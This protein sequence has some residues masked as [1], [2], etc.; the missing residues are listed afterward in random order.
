MHEWIHSTT[1]ALGY[2]GIELLMF[3]ENVFPPL[4]SELIMPLAGFA[5]AEGDLS[6]VGV[7]VAGSLGA[8][9]G[10]LPFYLLGRWLGEETLVSWADR[11]GRFLLL[12]GRDLERADRWFD[13]YGVQAVFFGRLVPG[14]RSLIPVPAGLSGMP[15]LRFLLYSLFG[16]VVWTLLLA[17]LGFVLRQNYALV[18]RYLG[19]LPL[20]VIGAIAVVAL[21]WLVRRLLARRPWVKPGK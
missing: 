1:T 5:A 4:P 6:L 3:I 20:V 13:R 7:I 18:G 16:T 14:L 9:L 12:S 19:S 2:P 15:V 11:Y 10:Q 8:L 21:G 17:L